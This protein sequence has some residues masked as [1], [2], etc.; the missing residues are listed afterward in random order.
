[1][2]K[3]LFTYN[4]LALYHIGKGYPILMMP[5]P[6]ASA[7]IPLNKSP[8]VE[9][10][11]KLGY[12]VLTFDPPGIY[13]SEK[14]LADVTLKEILDCTNAL[15]DFFKITYPFFLMGHSQSAFCSLVAVNK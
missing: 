1:M 4:G 7:F 11:N 9:I 5:Y 15:L 12:S 6:H 2:G 13:N 14:L 8:L 10:L 3:N